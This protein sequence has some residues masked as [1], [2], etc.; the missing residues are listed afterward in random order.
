VTAQPDISRELCRTPHRLTTQQ[1]EFVATRLSCS[2]DVQSARA[3]GLTDITARNWPNK[4]TVN[5][6]PRL[7][8]IGLF[9]ECPWMIACAPCEGCPQRKTDVRS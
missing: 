3:C 5:E 2:N 6:A 8:R 4:A 9:V 1:L 7:V